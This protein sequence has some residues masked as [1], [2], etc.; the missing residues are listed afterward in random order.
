Q[1]LRRR[2]PFVFA[3]F[4]DL[5]PA[6]V[7]DVELPW[8]RL[9]LAVAFAVTAMNKLIE[10]LSTDALVFEF[11]FVD[12]DGAENLAQEQALLKMILREQIANST[13]TVGTVRADRLA[14][15]CTQRPRRS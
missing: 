14:G 10:W 12:A 8:Q 11:L 1:S 6:R 13:A 15:H 5:A 9:I 4:P 7:K 2:R 3:L